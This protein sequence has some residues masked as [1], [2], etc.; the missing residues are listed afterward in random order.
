M[1]ERGTDVAREAAA[2][3]LLDDSFASI[4]AAI[5]Q[6]RHIDDNIRTA[7]RF[8]FA[9]HVPVIALA[10]VPTLMH[11]PLLLLP[12]QVVLFELIIDP[13]CSIVFEA[14]PAAAD[15]MERAPRPAGASPFEWANLVDGLVQGL[16]MAVILTLGS[17]AMVAQGWS[18]VDIRT[19]SFLALVGG[20]FLLV[21]A[22]RV[23][24]RGRGGLRIRNRWLVLL[25]LAVAAVLGLALGWP[26]LRQVMGFS[27]PSADMLWGV[28]L[29]VAPIALWLGA[30]HL[31]RAGRGS[32]RSGP[33][34]AA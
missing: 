12:A 23:S 15:L 34:R 30:L 18:G 17:A 27:P 5:R 6:G 2:I 11:W 24:W 3:V 7:V 29:M 14:E 8:I 16:G 28:A 20:V 31:A 22:N 33:G 10:L 9:V 13:A 32:L 19:A 1:G 26:W 21:P 25:L 4:T